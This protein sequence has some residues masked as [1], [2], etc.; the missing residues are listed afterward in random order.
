M[1]REWEMHLKQG[2]RDLQWMSCIHLQ[3]INYWTSSIWH[4][5]WTSMATPSF[6]NLKYV[7]IEG[8]QSDRR[9]CIVYVFREE[10]KQ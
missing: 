9:S 10:Q 1:H 8:E 7:A 3:R 4:V 6:L 5:E 2:K